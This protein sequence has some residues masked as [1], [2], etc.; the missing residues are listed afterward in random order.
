MSRSCAYWASGRRAR[1]LTSELV[2]ARLRVRSRRTWRGSSPST[3]RKPW[4]SRCSTRAS[5]RFAADFSA[6]STK[7]TRPTQCS[8]ATRFITFPTSGRPSRSNEPHGCS[9]PRGRASAPRHRSLVRAGRSARGD[10]FLARLS[11]HRSREGLDGDTTC[12]A[13]PRR[14][15]DVPVA[16]RADARPR[17]L[18]D[19]P[20]VAEPES[21]LRRVHVRSAVTTQRATPDG[22]A[23]PGDLRELRGRRRA[24][25]ARRLRQREGGPAS[26]A[27]RR[28]ARSRPAAPGACGPARPRPRRASTR[29]SA[30]PRCA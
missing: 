24:R 4:L 25:R 12:G 27:P 20:T 30:A 19:P 21:H 8:R 14:T 10:H 7:A 17:G 18:R 22:R 23:D 1:L 28:S 13:C 15:L 5:R 2:R 3:H 16:P 29:R 26:C 6:T 11:P 9:D